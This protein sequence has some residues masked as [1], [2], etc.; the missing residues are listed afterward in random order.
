M[1]KTNKS[2]FSI[3]VALL[4]LLLL[5]PAA[6]AA[7]KPADFPDLKGHWAAK[8]ILSLSAKGVLSGYPDGA[9]HPAQNI[10]RREL[11]KI[12]F[13]LF[14]KA[15]AMAP[16]GGDAPDYPDIH[17]GW[18][19]EYL[20]AAAY[21]LPGYTDG[22][23]KPDEPA[24][25]FEVAWLLLTAAMV[26]HGDSQ[27]ENDR[28][29]IKVPIP[30]QNAWQQIVKFK[31]YADLPQRYRESTAYLPVDPD[32][33]DFYHYAGYFFTDVNPVALLIGKDILDGYTDGTVGLERNVTRAETAVIVNRVLRA[34]LTI[35]GRYLLEPAGKVYFPR[36]V[37]LAS[38]ADATKKLDQAG[39]FLHNKYTD[40]LQRGRMIYNLMVHAFNYDWDTR[41]GL[42]Q[43][44]VTDIVGLMGAGRGTDQGLTR[45]YDA[46]ANAA[47]L[48]SRIVKGQATN[49][50][51]S[52][53]HTWI[54]LTVG[55]QTVPVDPTYGVCM[56]DVFFN[57]FTVWNGKGYQW[58][59]ETGR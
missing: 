24:T 10:S 30:D 59:K 18:G 19:Q 54:E 51:D 31:E 44:T 35:T 3:I 41:E 37:R 27:Q 13:T 23:F 7:A 42:E 48:D 53:A 22:S 43:S 16:S 29:L 26:D 21:Y 9:F 40:Q 39:E 15:A 25:R 5:L 57:N 20:H 49:P 28:L 11:A 14:P 33:K 8:E 1:L 50:S 12:T 55:G 32:K 4:Y 56:G 45:Y 38:A 58:N 36:T 2:F 6:A 47:W 34:T 46:L 17:S 52:G